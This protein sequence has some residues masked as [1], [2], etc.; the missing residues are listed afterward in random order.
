[1]FLELSVKERINILKEKVS[2][3]EKN[4]YPNTPTPQ[5]P[6]TKIHEWADLKN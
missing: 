2:T 1:M 6:N 3:L 5:H 4:K